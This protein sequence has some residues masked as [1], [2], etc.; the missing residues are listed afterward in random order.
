MRIAVVGE[1]SFTIGFR[2]AGIK[3]VVHAHD[4]GSFEDAVKGLITDQDIGIV[5]VSS[6]MLSGASP[7]FRRMA[8]DSTRPVVFP[9]GERKNTDIRNRIIKIVG[10]DLWK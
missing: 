9:M 5:I 6:A 3:D 4:T 1:E 10:V 7:A 8:E 2:L